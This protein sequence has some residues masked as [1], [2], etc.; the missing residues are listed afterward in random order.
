[1]GYRWAWVD[2]CCI[3]QT[4]NVEVQ[5]SVNSMFIWYHLSA[6][7]II[8]LSNVPP[9][10]LF[11][12]LARSAWNTRG[13]T[14]PEFLAPK[15]IRVYQNDWTPYLDDHSPNYKQSTAIM[16]EM[17]EVTGI[18]ARTLVAFR[19]GMI[20]A[21]EKLQWASTRV[22]TVEEDIAYSFFGI[23]DVQLPIMYGEKKQKA[24]G[25]LLQEIVA[26]SEDIT[27]L[28]WVGKSSEFNSCPPA[29]ITSYDT[30]SYTLPSISED[31]MQRLVSSL[32]DTVVL[33]LVLKLYGL[34]DRLSA[35]R[36]AHHRLHL[37][38]I[39]FPVTQI[40]RRSI[41][42]KE[43]FFMY[44][45]EADGLRDLKIT[46][47]DR[48]SQFS[49]GKPS[50]SSFLLIRPWDRRLLELPDYPDDMESVNDFAIPGS[51]GEQAAVD[52]KSSERAMRLI[53]RLG[54]PFSAFMLVQQRGKEY[55][56]VASDHDIITQ[57]KELT[58]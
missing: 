31:E 4:N 13:W 46:T 17:E 53:V 33:E 3:D 9:S 12:A 29:D 18:N 5:Q 8:Y 30:P 57:V 38:C 2:S 39:A 28:D 54:Q 43:T 47:E 25:R 21:R 32:Q 7:T 36:F 37:P 41:E 1:M 52:S 20:D 16:Q 55:K 22:T 50:R 11:G 44:E 42:H 19:P 48:L 24:L 23:F 10:F 27:A 15:V 14:L 6:L 26:K 35:P 49:R 34:L 58:V 40:R 45:V 51:S 56:R